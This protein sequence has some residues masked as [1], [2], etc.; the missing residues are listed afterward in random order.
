VTALRASSLFFVVWASTLPAAAEEVSMVVPPDVP[1]AGVSQADWSKAWWQWAGSFDRNLSPVADTTGEHCHL[2]Q[3]GA[4]W[5]LAGTYRTSRTLRTCTVPRGKYV[6][7]PLVNYVVMPRS[8]SDQ[9]CERSIATARSITDAP[10]MLV[11]DLDGRR[12][13]DLVKYRQ[14]TGECFDMG[15]LAQPRYRIFPSAANGYYVMLKPLSGCRYRCFGAP[16]FRRCRARARPWSVC[17]HRTTAPNAAR[18]GLVRTACR[19]R[20]AGRLI[21]GGE[22]TATHSS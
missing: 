11:M 20:P 6:F 14:A 12:L 15:V 10:S 22:P 16:S 7:F 2:G 17:R 21:A 8:S 1:V 3:Q 4:V 19:Q 5:F 9:N 13:V 18:N